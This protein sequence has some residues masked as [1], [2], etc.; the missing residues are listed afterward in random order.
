VSPKHLPATNVEGRTTRRRQ[1]STYDPEATSP[2]RPNETKG[3]EKAN[4][5]AIRLE[6]PATPTKQRTA[7]SSNRE[8]EAWFSAPVGEGV[9]LPPGL[10]LGV[11]CDLGGMRGASDIKN[12]N[13]EGRR[14]EAGVKLT[15]QRTQVS[16][17]REKEAWFSDPSRGGSFVSDP[18]AVRPRRCRREPRAKIH[19]HPSR[20]HQKSNRKPNL[21]ETHLTPTKY[22]IASPS[23]RKETAYSH[24]RNWKLAR[25][26]TPRKGEQTRKQHP[27][28]M[29]RLRTHPILY[30]LQFASDFNRTM[31][32]L[33]EV[34]DKDRGE[35]KSK[36]GQR[37]GR[38]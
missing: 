11:G 10:G 27:P 2:A 19:I 23:N 7:L 35:R 29:F 12:S 36:G 15:K 21:L 18:P 33:S 22:A 32:R 34:R 17:N 38:N 28:F 24:H 30:F 8:K 1:R 13:R 3:E 6:T 9:Y 4:R 14:L 5:E 25:R 16:S 37:Q 31:F 26:K 20:S